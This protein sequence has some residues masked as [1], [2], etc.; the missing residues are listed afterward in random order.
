V[1]DQAPHSHPKKRPTRRPASSEIYGST[2]DDTPSASKL[3]ALVDGP[4]RVNPD[5]EKKSG[6]ELRRRTSLVLYL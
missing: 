1:T 5:D 6:E 3:L 4:G 2:E